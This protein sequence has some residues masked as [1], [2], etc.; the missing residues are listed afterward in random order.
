MTNKELSQ[1]SPLAI[2]FV[3]D[4]VHTL[5]LRDYIIKN[6][7]LKQAN[8]HKEVS[9]F[10]NAKS[11]AQALDFIYEELNEEEKE[12]VRRARNSKSKHCAKNFS[13]EDY[14]KATSFEALIGY[15][16]LQDN[17]DRLDY[18]LKKIYNF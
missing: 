9:K 7:T 11:Q 2:A 1:M 12:I 5:Y 10:C 8:Y 14:K 6:Q 15:L 17:K 13:E 4:A 18:I 3:G 16:Y